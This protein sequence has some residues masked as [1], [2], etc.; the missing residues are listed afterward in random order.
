MKW[1]GSFWV[2]DLIF[3]CLS[4]VFFGLYFFLRNKL[5]EK[6]RDKIET[7]EEK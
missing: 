1:T 7:V 2:T 6:D 3:Y 5:K 4:A